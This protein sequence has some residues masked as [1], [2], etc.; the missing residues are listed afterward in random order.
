MAIINSMFVAVTL[1]SIAGSVTGIIFLLT[2]R[3]IYKFTTA[4][5]LVNINKIVIL[6]FVIPFFWI[7]GELDHSNE[8]FLEYD[9]VVLVQEHSLKALLYEISETINFANVISIIWITG[10][11]AY[12]LLQAI[13]YFRFNK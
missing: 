7:L 5:F 13:L 8:L 11:L 12:L 9:L 1:L 10:V 2:Q 3:I 6:T 4:N